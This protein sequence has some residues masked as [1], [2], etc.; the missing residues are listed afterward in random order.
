[1][2]RLKYISF[3]I[4]FF[5]F[6]HGFSCVALLVSTKSKQNEQKSVTLILKCCLASSDDIKAK[7]TKVWHGF[8]MFSSKQNWKELLHW[9]W[10]V[11]WRSKK[12]SEINCKY[13]LKMSQINCKYLFNI[14][15]KWIS[16]IFQKILKWTA[17]IFK[18]LAQAKT[19]FG[20][21]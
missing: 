19:Y 15:F 20:P 10:C 13:F 16:N 2:Q 1:M 9:E 21:S 4:G 6:L 18:T 8:L 3:K 12:T 5:F 17:Y 14:F 11:S 7:W